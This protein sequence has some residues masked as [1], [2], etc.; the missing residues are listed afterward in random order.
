MNNSLMASFF[1]SSIVINFG[2]GWYFKEIFHFSV[3]L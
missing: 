3:F 1:A 2:Y